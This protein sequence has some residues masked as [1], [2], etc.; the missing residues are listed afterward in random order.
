M[1]YIVELL[2]KANIKFSVNFEQMC[3]YWYTC[4]YFYLN[5][6]LTYWFRLKFETIVN[7]VLFRLSN[8]AQHLLYTLYNVQ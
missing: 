6:W 8:Y 3:I 4:N 7:A 1:I 2:N 5:I